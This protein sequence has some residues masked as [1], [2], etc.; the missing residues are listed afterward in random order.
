MRALEGKGLPSG[1][2]LCEKAE[3]KGAFLPLLF[4]YLSIHFGFLSSRVAIV[5]RTNLGTGSLA[6]ATP[7]FRG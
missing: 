6:V 5:E 3:G 2:S 7:L 4:L 1:G